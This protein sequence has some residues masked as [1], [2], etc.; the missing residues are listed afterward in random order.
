M[1]LYG[2]V[3][4]PVDIVSNSMTPLGSLSDGTQ[5]WK[6]TQN[7]VDTHPMHFHLA[8]VQVLNRV[9]WDGALLPP[10]PNELGWKETV[11]TN[12]LEHLIVAMRPI[13]ANPAL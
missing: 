11:R 12:P 2:Y 13:A 10:E 1:S 8:N 9:A 5:I 6:I 3:S 4:P 7:G